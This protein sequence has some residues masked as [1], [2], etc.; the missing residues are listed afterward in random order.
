MGRTSFKQSRI[1]IDGIKAYY[2]N[3]S[4]I[5]AFYN[6]PAV[7]TTQ[8][9]FMY[10]LN[11]YTLESNKETLPEQRI[12]VQNTTLMNACNVVERST[13]Q[14]GLRYLTKMGVINDRVFMTK[15]DEYSL[16]DTGVKGLTKR[17]ILFNITKAKEFLQMM[18]GDD[19]FNEL[20]KRS[21]ERRLV[22]RR[23]LSMIDFLN[24]QV[25]KTQVE[26]LNV[27]KNRNRFDKY[28]KKTTRQIR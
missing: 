7:D 21:R 23:P 26:D 27:K 12:Y 1:E 2:H 15:D 8:K 11:L 18:P 10:L 17:R 20:E 25:T 3:E 19:N 24:K 22:Y 16:K 28:L 4:T 14:K 5:E 9:V 13:V 6:N